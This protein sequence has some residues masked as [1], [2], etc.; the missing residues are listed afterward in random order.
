MS[1]SDA[2][3]LSVI[4][5]NKLEI[6][7]VPDS[8]LYYNKSGTAKAANDIYIDCRPVGSS[9]EVEEPATE[10]KPPKKP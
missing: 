2:Q 1:S 4:K 10:K 9:G 8:G 3:H 6:H 7:K 5:E